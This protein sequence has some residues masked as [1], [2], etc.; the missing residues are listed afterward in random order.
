MNDN[1]PPG[2][3]SWELDE[4]EEINLEEP[5]DADDDSDLDEDEKELLGINDEQ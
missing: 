3:H 2:F 5:F 1:Y 4:P